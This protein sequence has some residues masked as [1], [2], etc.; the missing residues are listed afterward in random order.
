MNTN[1]LVSS[2]GEGLSIE[3]DIKRKIRSA[4]IL[5]ML[6]SSFDKLPDGVNVYFGYYRLEITC[7]S[8]E[9]TTACLL[10]F[11]GKW[12]REDDG[13]GNLR[14][15][16]LLGLE[17]QDSDYEIQIIGSPPP[18]CQVVEEVVEVPATTT[19]R[20]RIVCANATDDV[21]VTV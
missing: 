9:E 6:K 14:Y 20:K 5:G 21:E 18:S 13:Y 7:V 4:Y 16:R 8:R 2:I 12:E 1:Q 15:H 10:A 3:T 11:G 17:G 19:L